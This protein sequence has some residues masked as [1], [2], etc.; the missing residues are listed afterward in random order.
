MVNTFIMCPLHEALFRNSHLTYVPL[1]TLLLLHMTIVRSVFFIT[2]IDLLDF[3]K[4]IKTNS[5]IS[6]SF[7]FV[8]YGF[9]INFLKNK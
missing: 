7:L 8:S 1:L 2:F 4:N 9:R 3:R 5:S 6:L